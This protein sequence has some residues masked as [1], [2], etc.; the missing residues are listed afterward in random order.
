MFSEMVLRVRQA[1]N[2][3]DGILLLQIPHSF[4]SL[5]LSLDFFIQ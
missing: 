1:Y 4:Q 3:I 5:S 2:H